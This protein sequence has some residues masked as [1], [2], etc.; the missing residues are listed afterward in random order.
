MTAPSE[1]AMELTRKIHE[2]SC[3]V[4]ANRS[5]VCASCDA[6]LLD[7]ACLIDES[8]AELVGAFI[9]FTEYADDH[10]SYPPSLRDRVRAALAP[11][12][13]QRMGGK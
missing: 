11:F 4:E 12:K 6:D 1:A 10:L 2:L 5:D 9:A 3:G 7:Y 13:L 8:V